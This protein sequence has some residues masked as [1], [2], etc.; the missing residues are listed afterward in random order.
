[1]CI[2]D[3]QL[4]VVDAVEYSVRVKCI[5]SIGVSSA[6]TTATRTIIGATEIP[7]D[8]T[9]LSI[10]MVGSNQMEL[11]WRPVSDLDCS[12]YELRFQNVTSGATWN[13]S[14]PLTK[15][16]RRKSD[17]VT[18][19][20]MSGVA[21]MIKCVDKLGNSSAKENIVYTNISGLQYYSNQATYTE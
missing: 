20:S 13:A 15:V 5:N 11:T 2:R 16:T 19:N 4:N 7:E 8:V 1:M 17:S 10:S 6:Y 12:F 18:V 3:R 14:T 21:I 9:D